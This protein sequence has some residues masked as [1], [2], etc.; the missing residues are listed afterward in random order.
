MNL[1]CSTSDQ[2]S[3]DLVMVYGFLI[4]LLLFAAESSIIEV[5][6]SSLCCSA[7]MPIR[8]RKRERG[9]IYKLRKER[10]VTCE[11][12]GRGLMSRVGFCLF[13]S[14]GGEGLS[15]VIEC[16]AYSHWSL[17][18]NE[19]VFYSLDGHRTPHHIAVYISV[20]ITDAENNFNTCNII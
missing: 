1:S 13:V 12:D 11:G 5:I 15:R 9:R 20:I 19:L 18:N 17:K 10:V 8:T 6:S 3:L 2:L 14:W 7:E 4:F 16:I